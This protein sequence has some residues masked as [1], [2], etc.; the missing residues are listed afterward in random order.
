[1]KESILNMLKDS[2][3]TFIS[4]QYISEK[5]GVS[6]TAIWKY[7]NQLKNDGYKIESVS[8]KG[9]KLIYSP[10]LLTF[11]EIHP[12]LTTSYIGNRIL[13]FD[14]IT[15]TN[16]KAKE[17]ALNNYPHGSV[18]IAEEQTNGRGRLGRSWISPKYKGIWMSII[19]RPNINTLDVPKVTQVTAAAVEKSLLNMNLK[20]YIKW[21]NDIIL[22]SKKICGI[23]T[24]MSGEINNVNYVVVGI[25]IN[26]NL[27][28]EDLDGD[29]KEKATSIKIEE[30]KSIKR[31]LLV[32]HILNNF[33]TLYND[34]INFN[35]IESSIHICK[36]NS[37]LIGKNI[38][39]MSRKTITLAKALSLNEN[40]ELIVQ[41]ENGKIVKVNSGEVSIRGEN[42][43]I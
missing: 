37:I 1:M 9:Y 25:G 11:E 6:R 41:Y 29:L 39:I 12:L 32:A 28:V 3:D 15:S 23:L 5:L 30:N 33:E 34:L 26:A 4:G 13:Y 2:S 19:L 17:L 43:Y 24:E 38:K 22:N 18:I 36:E 8:K 35:N 27:D 20:T 31:K 40:G 14:S 7:I 10:D 21:P 16:D 42:G